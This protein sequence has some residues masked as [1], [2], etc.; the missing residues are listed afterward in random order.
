MTI[1]LFQQRQSRHR[2][3]TSVNGNATA[4]DVDGDVLTFS[5]GSEPFAM[6]R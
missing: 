1:L 4:T 3:D 2:E 6:E 5:K